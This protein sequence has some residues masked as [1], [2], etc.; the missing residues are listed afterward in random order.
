[1]HHHKV[2]KVN[3]W[4]VNF[5]GRKSPG[6][7]L[8]VE[9]L[10][11]LGAALLDQRLLCG[12]EGQRPPGAAWALQGGQ[13]GR[14]GRRGCHRERHTVLALVRG[15]SGP[16]LA[17]AAL[18]VRLDRQRLQPQR[19]AQHQTVRR[20]AGPERRHVPAEEAPGVNASASHGSNLH[21]LQHSAAMHTVE[22][23]RGAH[24]EQGEEDYG[25]ED[26]YVDLVPP[27]QLGQLC[28]AGVCGGQPRVLDPLELG[29]VGLDGEQRQVV[30]HGAAQRR[31][32]RGELRDAARTVQAELVLDQRR[33]AAVLRFVLVPHDFSLMTTRLSLTSESTTK[34]MLTWCNFDGHTFPRR[35]WGSA[36]TG[37]SA[38]PAAPGRPSGCRCWTRPRRE[39]GSAGTWSGT[40][41]RLG[42][43]CP[44]RSRKCP[45]PQRTA[46]GR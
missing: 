22:A 35:V 30:V 13:S 33:A 34:T 16:A 32:G 25:G 19:L 2:I 20:G 12:V 8:N 6:L 24:G 31:G 11:L 42:R 10:D 9:V 36:R 17:R 28:G 15:C 44:C 14:L 5:F 39:P 21:P 23:H 26:G 40:A 38:A 7:L 1:M 41:A 29:Q 46:S 4:K 43:A 37:T 18:H 27:E 3:F 45:V